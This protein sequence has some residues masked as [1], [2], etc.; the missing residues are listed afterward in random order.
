[1]YEDEQQQLYFLPEKGDFFISDLSMKSFSRINKLPAL[2]ANI[3]TSVVEDDSGCLWLTSDGGLVRFCNEK[4]TLFNYMHGIP[5]PTFTHYTA[6]RDQHGIL[7]FGNSKGLLYVDPAN[8]PE[9]EQKPST[10][11]VLSDLLVNGN[12]L[13]L[14]ELKGIIEEKQAIFE[15]DQNNIVFRF[16]DFSY[17][18]PSAI[19]VEYKM[20]K[21]DDDWKFI[22][23]QNEISYFNLSPGKYIFRMRIPG[24]EDSQVSFAIQIRQSPFFKSRTFLFFLFGILLIALLYYVTVLLKNKVA[25][26]PE[27]NVLAADLSDKE[28]EKYKMNRMSTEECDVLHE[29]LN[30]YMQ[31]EKP[32]MNK[33]LK[34]GDL[35]DALHTSSHSLSYLF[36]QYLN[37][38]YYDFVNEWRIAEFKKLVAEDTSSKYTLEVLADLCG[39][40]SR[41]SF[42]RSFKKSMG[43]TP[44]EYIK[45]LR[46]H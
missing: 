35:A 46:G 10:T 8:V 42:F 43:I 36:N 26:N 2:Q 13:S 30:K 18:N 22:T 11:F 45:S 40:S 14:K 41:A 33:E 7:W 27:D 16:S 4:Y 20:D 12:S 17:T 31:D 3:Y 29:A 25:V 32:Y 24:N 39:F 9:A 28:E 19:L 15:Y 38:S 5:S 1:M 21:I 23:G 37:V 6:Y 44:N 34:I